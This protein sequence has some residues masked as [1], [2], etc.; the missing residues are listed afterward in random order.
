MPNRR[1]WVSP[2][3]NAPQA[4]AVLDHPPPMGQWIEADHVPFLLAPDP[5][6]VAPQ[7]G[8]VELLVSPLQTPVQHAPI[9]NWSPGTPYPGPPARV[10]KY[11]D[12]DSAKWWGRTGQGQLVWSEHTEFSANLP[13]NIPQ[14]M[15][16]HL[17]NFQGFWGGYPNIARNR[18]SAWS[19]QVPTANPVV[20][21]LDSLPPG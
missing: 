9:T 11:I 21:A 12:L 4:D 18:P 20:L 6:G 17:D 3:D 15:F 8:S 13:P 1:R 14:D 2:S 19:D 5:G 7:A 10:H 16:Q